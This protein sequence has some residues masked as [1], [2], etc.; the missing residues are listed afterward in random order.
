MPQERFLNPWR[1]KWYPRA[2]VFAVVVAVFIAV[3]GGKGAG[4]L[5]GRLGG[6]YV[7]FY[8]A[9]RILHEAT[10]RK[11]YR[12]SDD[13]AVQKDLF[14]KEYADG[15]GTIPFPY[16]PFVALAYYPL[17]L[18]NYRL[19]YLLHTLLMMLALAL[20]TRLLA[21]KTPRLGGR[22]DLA[23]AAVLLYYPMLRAALGGQNNP[24][25][26]LLYVAVWRAG[27]SGMEWLAGLFLGLM[28]FKPQF[29]IPL[30]GLHLL[31]G[32]YRTVMSS[33][34]VGS[35]LYLI[36][37]YTYG[38]FWITDWLHYASWSTG[39][40]ASLD[41][42]SNLCWLGFLQA[43]LGAD[44]R[45]ALVAGWTMALATAV[46][47]SLVWHKGRHDPD[48]SARFG[49]A[50]AALILIPPHAQY[51][52]MGLI[53]FTYAMCLAREETPVKLMALLWLLAPI[54]LAEGIL[55]FSPL[56]FLLLLSGFMASHVLMPAGLR[57]RRNPAPRQGSFL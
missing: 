32:R 43:L 49:L 26:F 46:A 37:M 38:R 24:I 7:D 5:T 45:V 8:G 47:I 56:F 33:M 48:L 15:E 1:L 18:L 27:S 13:A 40:S 22:Y 42:G 12:F 10:G 29:A 39:I 53:L 21:R 25:T 6:D 35:G 34:L 31:S 30:I 55:G 57:R 52:D 3:L 54:Q 23:L 28:L 50:A 16:P 51:Y 11:L 44:S 20:A 36:G 17:A 41:R 4:T 2:A 9:G 19:S 14:P